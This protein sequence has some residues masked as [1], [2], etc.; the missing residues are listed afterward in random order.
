[1]EIIN[2]KREADS[3]GKTKEPPRAC[4]TDKCLSLVDYFTEDDKP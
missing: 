3:D 1:L 2:D 4:V